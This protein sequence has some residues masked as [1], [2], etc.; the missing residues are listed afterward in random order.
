M[1]APVKRPAA[2]NP[3]LAGGA[4]LAL[5]PAVCLADEDDALIAR[6]STRHIAVYATG[7]AQWCQPSL[8]LKMVLT[9][10]SADKGNQ[11]AQIAL[12]DKMKREFEQTCP[13]A[14]RAD[15][16]IVE[17]GTT[18]GHFHAERSTGWVF[19]AAPVPVSA[20]TAAPTPDVPP[21]VT[22]APDAAAAPTAPADTAAQAPQP[23]PAPAPAPAPVV[24]AIPP[25]TDQGYW[26]YL[27]L[28]G[29]NNPD[30]FARD[31][32]QRCWA[33]GHMRAEW[34]QA[35]SDDFRQHEVLTRAQQDMQAQSGSIGPNLIYAGVQI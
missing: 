30:F 17:E 27:L 21:F 6:S 23:A 12:L 26:G 11:P 2:L 35:G 9:S 33:Q 22:A 19:A 18:T 15:A 32:V 10:E 14:E 8:T 34:S 25:E 7:G 24:S 1:I 29:K 4:A 5:L 3:R 16:S 28:A 20:P 13:I 31:E